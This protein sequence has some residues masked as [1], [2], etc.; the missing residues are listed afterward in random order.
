MLELK[1]VHKT[2]FPNKGNSVDAL[3]N[4]SLKIQNKGLVFIV[5]KS[6]SGKTTLL[7]LIGGLDECTKGQILFNGQSIDYS[8]IT[9]LD[10]YRANQIGFIFQEY[11]LLDELTVYENIALST[12]LLGYKSSSNQVDEVLNS[13]G[14][15]NMGNRYPSELSTGQKQRVAIARALIKKP[16]IILADEPTGSLDSETSKQIFTLLKVLSAI[17]TVIV[18][19][20]DKE[21]ANIYGDR[22]IELHDGSVI[23]DSSPFLG[24]EIIDETSIPNSKRKSIYTKT[25]SKISFKNLLKKPFRLILS[26]L[27]TTIALLLFSLT[28]AIISYQK[29]TTIQSSMNQADILWFTM[30]KKIEMTDSLGYEVTMEPFLSEEDLAN[31]SNRFPE[32]KFYPIFNQFSCDFSD[33]LFYSNA[34]N[35][36]YTRKISGG[37]EITNQIISELNFSIVAGRIPA[38][39]LNDNEIMISRYLF[40]QF[41]SFGYRATTNSPLIEVQSYDKILNKS[42]SINGKDYIIVGII[43]TN[44]DFERYQ[45]INNNDTMDTGLST[46]L[47]EIEAMTSSGIHS[48]VFLRSGYYQDVVYPDSYEGSYI[49]NNQS[50]LVLNLDKYA[51]ESD[52]EGAKTSFYSYVN[53]DFIPNDVIWKNGTKLDTLNGNQILLPVLSIPDDEFIGTIPSFSSQLTTKSLELIN[54][55]AFNHFDEIKDQYIDNPFYEETYEDYADYIYN[56]TTNGNDYHSGFDRSYFD[57]EA[58]KQILETTYFDAFDDLQISRSYNG[59]II[60][61]D[62]EVVGFYESTMVRGE[63]GY[64]V[65]LSEN[66]YNQFLS[67]SDREYTSVI[68][69]ISNEKSANSQL[70][71]FS[72]E[73]INNTQYPLSDQVSINIEYVSHILKTLSSIMAYVGVGFLVFSILMFFNFVSISLSMRQKEIGIL[74]ALGANKKTI[75]TIF[76]VESLLIAL[77]DSIIAML[78]FSITTLALNTTLMN[79]YGMMIKLINGSIRQYILIFVIAFGST[80]ISSFFP[81]R[82]LLKYKPVDIIK[83][84]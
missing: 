25:I 24:D 71:S 77:V 83:N 31:L 26:I 43:D 39:S 45:D 32:F 47:R 4:V 23:N 34:D 7:N 57:S 36:L 19:T 37:F 2:Y 38:Y 42:L 11:N 41:K 9:Y 44:F 53:E 8:K 35:R 21:S 66:L 18:I 54:T 75:F 33:N 10:D 63:I 27:L 50:P 15:S 17:Q 20:H 40:E 6:G 69:P 81:L 84:S 70:I 3:S 22:I 80:L 48:S 51:I 46:L 56:S 79:N 73:L 52:Y 76:S 49:I 30:T 72:D 64:P 14:L 16:S 5:G 28:D 62:I 60:I 59:D 13:V 1:N 74:V 55:F 67:V 65:I 29:A 82:K 58:K 12:E 61:N 78:L 68:I